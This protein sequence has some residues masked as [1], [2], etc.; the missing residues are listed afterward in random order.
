MT[1]ANKTLLLV[2]GASQYS[3]PNLMEKWLPTLEAGLGIGWEVKLPEMPNPEAPT[4]EAW[5]QAIAAAQSSIDGR[6]FMAG[7]SLGGSTL[8]QHVARK[9]PSVEGLFV[10]AAPF[11]CGQDRGWQ[12]EA[13][14][15]SQSEVARL[16]HFQLSFY[17]GTAD[18]IVPFNHLAEYQ[19]VFPEATFRTYPSMNHIDPTAVFL[20]DLV[21]D[22][23]EAT[24]KK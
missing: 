2:H 23:L 5:L 16:Q 21:A 8:L 13:F 18:D 3:R 7:H 1:E 19:K 10:A 24:V 12:H 4:A 11:W 6:M 15:L 14:K 9:L 20:Q 17:H 22:M